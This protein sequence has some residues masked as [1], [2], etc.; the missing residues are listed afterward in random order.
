M[1]V[2]PNL[3]RQ[4]GGRREERHGSSMAAGEAGIHAPPSAWAKARQGS[5]WQAVPPCSQFHGRN[6]SLH[7]A[8]GRQKVS[9]G[10]NASK[11]GGTSGKG[12]W[13]RLGHVIRKKWKE[14]GKGKGKASKS[15]HKVLQS[16][17][18]RKGSGAAR[19][20]KP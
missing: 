16:I 20:K 1:A 17:Q 11:A 19:A 9:V 7:K 5:R 2:A 8:T 6:G 15:Q 14:S 3:G 18:S 4:H 13:G 12:K 10:K